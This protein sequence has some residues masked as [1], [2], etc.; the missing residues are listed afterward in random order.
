[1]ST[2][3]RTTIARR[4][5]STRASPATTTSPRRFATRRDDRVARAM[6]VQTTAVSTLIDA[7]ICAA[8][9]MHKGH[10]FLPW[11]APRVIFDVCDR[12]DG[13][14]RRGGRRTFAQIT[15]DGDQV[16]VRAIDTVSNRFTWTARFDSTAPIDA[17][18]GWTDGDAFN[19]ELRFRREDE[20]DGE[21]L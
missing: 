2:R 8:R 13:A 17:V 7:S 1:M 3:R 9:K 12:I 4:R 11:N 16:V 15:G 20:H 19:G 21:G 10:D 5:C 14:G 6:S 18:V